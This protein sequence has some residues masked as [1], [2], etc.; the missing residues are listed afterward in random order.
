[1]QVYLE[2]KVHPLGTRKQRIDVSKGKAESGINRERVSID[3]VRYGVLDGKRANNE[4]RVN[5]LYSFVQQG[6]F[7]LQV[8]DMA[9]CSIC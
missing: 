8:N 9:C 6:M 7:C 3:V 2:H 5:H 4:R 1:M